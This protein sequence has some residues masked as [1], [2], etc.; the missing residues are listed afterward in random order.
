M[1]AAGKKGMLKVTFAKAGRYPFLCT[2]PSHAPA[3]MKGV[4]T[5]K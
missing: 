5:V 3:G 1:I 2:L 4:L